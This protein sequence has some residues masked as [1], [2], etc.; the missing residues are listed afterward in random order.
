MKK[1]GLLFFM[2]GI[3]NVFSQNQLTYK[4]IDSI[5]NTIYT[6]NA[7]N[8][9]K[10]E[11]ICTELYYQ[12]KEINYKKG[13]VEA[14]L[15]KIAFRINSRN[16]ENVQQYLDEAVMLANEMQD[17]FYLTKA[18][19]ME[20][21]ML[22]HL[23][24]N[25]E[26]KKNLDQNIKLIPKIKDRNKRLFM[27]TYYYARYIQLYSENNDSLLHYS[28]KRLKSALAL[29]DSDRD[30]PGVI[31]STAGYLTHYYNQ[32]KNVKKAEYYLD[33]QKKYIQKIDNLF[34]LINY[35]KRK[36]EFIYDYHK[37]EKGYLDSALYHFKKAEG[38]AEKY[39]SPEFLE[40]LYP[41]I[42]H[43]YEDKK[44]IEKQASYLNKH[45][46][47]TDSIIAND[48]KTI[49]H[50]FDKKKTKESSQ[51][52]K[53]GFSQNHWL[54]LI[55]AIFLILII[56]LILKR[57]SRNRNNTFTDNQSNK[58]SYNNPIAENE[59]LKKLALENN[60]AFFP[61]FLEVYPRFK[62]NLLKIN[63]TLTHSEIEF[64]ALLKLNLN[65]IQIA[66]SK[67]MSIRA[68]DSKKYRVRKKLKRSTNENLY[69]W[70]SK[71]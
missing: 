29:P 4:Q 69:K 38:Y 3:I 22:M 19:A 60:I 24:L 52:E 43:V 70:M 13:Q 26:G 15:R 17:Y 34:D 64:C 10:I 56:F 30:K 59:R 63:S 41:E 58:H 65:S 11:A 68:V 62:E 51:K 20:A 28:K 2:L 32:E 42:A 47:I 44:E 31:L 14:L 1:I 25:N 27:E 46:N 55:P 18:K 53:K 21:S 12:S 6:T 39:N 57:Q 5:Q 8:A 48:I 9:D 61:S 37:N 7:T 40:L 67:K 71:I 50:I 35:H 16:Y 49:D 45:A 36:A 33:V 54:Y 66:S 23:Q